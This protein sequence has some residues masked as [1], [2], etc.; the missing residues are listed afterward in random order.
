MTILGKQD[1]ARAKWERFGLKQNGARRKNAKSGGLDWPALAKASFLHPDHAHAATYQA[2]FEG[3]AQGG[4]GN[5]L[6]FMLHAHLWAG[7]VPLMRF[8]PELAAL[9]ARKKSLLAFAATEPESGSD[10]FGLRTRA[11]KTKEGW[12]LTGTKTF[13]TNAT[14][15][16]HLLVLAKPEGSTHAQDLACF[17]V[18]GAAKGVKRRRQ[19]LLGLA[20][21][22]VGE[23]QL[24]NVRVAE[25]Q[26]VGK[27][28]QG[29]D[30]FR[31]AMAWE[32]SLILANAPARL[33]LLAAALEKEA[34]K[35]VRSG[36]P[37]S[38][39]TR[40]A[41]A[42]AS[43]RQHAAEIRAKIRH[44]AFELD[45]GAN[46]FL[47][48]ART[49]L[50]ASILYEEASRTLLQLGGKEAFLSG[51]AIEENF[52]DSLASALYSGP[53][54]LLGALLEAAE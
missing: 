18:P 45:S 7:W 9:V 27:L 6:L 26:L 20:E 38:T 8:A 12:L 30:I 31:L 47:V 48:S 2:A 41:G 14:R 29:A 11:K 34:G 50:E 19:K 5:S 54:D 51:S 4:C 44:A 22:D 49:K 53:N 13:I 15:A 37:L 43:V 40:F 16:S 46:A 35:K 21:A 3:L 25:K 36:K 23:I 52:R 39:N 28:R 32:R 10:I 17:L 1:E 24:R 42:V 33:E